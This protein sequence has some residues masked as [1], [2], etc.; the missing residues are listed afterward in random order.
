MAVITSTGYCAA[1]L[2]PTS[3]D[4][5]FQDGVIEVY[6]G[7]QPASA[8]VA[9]TG[10]L[11]A[12]ITRD[13]AAWTAGASAGGLRFIR[14]GR[15]VAKDAAQEW[16]LTGLAMGVAGWFRLLPNAADPGVASLTAPRIDGAVGVIGEPVDAQI[17]LPD[18]AITPETVITLNYWWYAMPP[19][20]D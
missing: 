15:Y 6:S 10:T 16:K 19:I 8:D 12:R 20:G 9:P 5:L 14:D 1:I 4:A 3:F 11:L 18:T 2:G 17:Y 13:G 7:M